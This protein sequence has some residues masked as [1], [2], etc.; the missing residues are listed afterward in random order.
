MCFVAFC[1]GDE[2]QLAD[3]LTPG[4]PAAPAAGQ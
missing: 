1:H 2:D 4:Q 3:D